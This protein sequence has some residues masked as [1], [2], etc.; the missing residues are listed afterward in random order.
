MENRK[1]KYAVTPMMHALM[2]AQRVSAAKVERDARRGK[3]LR[4]MKGDV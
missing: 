2:H 3:L 1:A 4:E